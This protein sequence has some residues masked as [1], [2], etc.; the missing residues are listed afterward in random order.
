M[1]KNAL[2]LILLMFVPFLVLSKSLENQWLD[3]ANK[4]YTN[5]AYDKAASAYDT[6]LKINPNN[7]SALTFG[8]YAYASLNN[9]SKALQYLQKAYELS[10]DSNIKA[11]IDSIKAAGGTPEIAAAHASKDSAY[12]WFL[13]GADIILAGAATYEY[14]DFSKANNNYNNEYAQ[15]DNTTVDNYNLLLSMRD[16][17]VSKQTT[18]DVLM[19]CAGTAIAYT[20]I[21]VFFV[22]AAFPVT[23]G[24]A[25]E[26]QQVM[27]T[28]NMEF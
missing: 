25:P 9:Q 3:Y 11:K 19:A 21:D 26:K 13:L 20:L 16:T 22:H 2:M 7:V 23:A 8:G 24:Y 18:C 17:V 6:V 28:Y 12:K 5:Q 27:I 15:I 10:G 1:K 14:L 4:C